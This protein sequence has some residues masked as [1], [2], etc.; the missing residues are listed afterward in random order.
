MS[1]PVVNDRPKLTLYAAIALTIFGAAPFV[2]ALLRIYPISDEGHA[3]AVKEVLAQWS[4]WGQM[5][6]FLAAI[7][8]GVA[9]LM[10]VRQLELQRAELRLQRKELGLTRDELKRSAVAQEKSEQA[11]AAQVQQ[12]V[13]ASYLNAASALAQHYSEAYAQKPEHCDNLHDIARNEN[14]VDNPADRTVKGKMLF[15]RGELERLFLS[16]KAPSKFE[17]SNEV[18]MPAVEPPVK[19]TLDHETGKPKRM[20]G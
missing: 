15:Y 7:F 14:R 1:D 10:M 4:N 8:S 13:N 6:G 9:L 18:V 5:F 3:T 20:P 16:L 17:P 19:Y 2:V 12:S 11:L